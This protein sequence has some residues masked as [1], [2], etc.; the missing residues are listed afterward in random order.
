MIDTKYG[1][2]YRMY[3]VELDRDQEGNITIIK[4]RKDSSDEFL[5]RAAMTMAH[6][7]ESYNLSVRLHIKVSS[8]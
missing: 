5:E 8:Y 7:G 4:E 1:Q 3:E 2:R 6:V